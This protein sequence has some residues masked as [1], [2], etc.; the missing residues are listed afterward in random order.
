MRAFPLY[1]E[2]HPSIHLQAITYSFPLLCFARFPLLVSARPATDHSAH[3][4]FTT[5]FQYVR[6][7]GSWANHCEHEITIPSTTKRY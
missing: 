7:L 5:L 4:P 1:P 6:I 3:T 2:I